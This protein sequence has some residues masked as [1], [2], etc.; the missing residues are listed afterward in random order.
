MKKFV[1]IPNPKKDMGFALSASV[2]EKLKELGGTVYVSEKI[3]L[4][5][6]DVS[7]YSAFPEDAEC[8]IVIGGDGSILDASQFC[9]EYDVPLIGINL[10]KMGYLS[11]LEP[12]NTDDLKRLISDD[13]LIR[14]CMLL[15]TEVVGAN[16]KTEISRL[17]L[18]DIGVSHKSGMGMSVFSLSDAAEDTVTYHA[19]GV[20]VSTPA[21]STAYSLSAGGPIVAPGV[22]SMLVTPLSPHS[23]FNRSILFDENDVL[24]IK[25]LGEDRMEIC[26]DGR[27]VADLFSGEICR[28][29]KS[30]K[31]LKMITLSENTMFRTL[32]TKMR[33][34]DE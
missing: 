22:H 33:L 24:S 26:V 34:L 16:G 15:S 8:I 27:P 28:V 6:D 20:L 7:L 1:L 10:G 19:D 30:D 5:R 2:V 12:A 4:R 21:G 17:A 31:K 11:E 23:F 32:F 3:G 14:D 18:N 25:N 13:F 9:C 29:F